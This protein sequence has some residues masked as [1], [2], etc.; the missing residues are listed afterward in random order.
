[1][2][3]VVGAANILMGRSH[4]NNLSALDAIRA[5]CADILVSDYFPAA[6]LH[7]VFQLYE[8]GILSL[9]EAV[10]MAA[11]SSGKGGEDRRPAGLH[12]T[13]KMRRPASGEQKGPVPVI[14]SVLINGEE[15]T[16]LHYRNDFVGE[17][18]VRYD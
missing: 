18:G 15:V 12:R 17:D 9:P 5:G 11:L 1:M 2:Q 8:Q 6:I 16:R 14:L 10:N 7:A 3:V 13:W 4:S